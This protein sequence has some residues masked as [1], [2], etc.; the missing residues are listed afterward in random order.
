[1]A[2]DIAVIDLGRLADKATFVDPHQYAEGVEW[3][4]VGGAPVVEEGKLTWRLPGKVL[5]RE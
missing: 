3:V 2:A 1:M 5:V 4:L